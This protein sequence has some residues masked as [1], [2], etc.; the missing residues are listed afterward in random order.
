MSSSSLSKKLVLL[1]FIVV[2]L[3]AVPLTIFM[4]QRQQ[5]IRSR[6]APSTTLSFSPTTQSTTVGQ[7][8]SFD[9]MLDPGTNQV[10]FLKL[11]INYD[12]VKLAKGDDGLKANG[13][14]FPSTLE[15]PTFATNAASITLSIGA[16]PTKVIT[17]K[18]KAATISFT[19]L[20][21]T[22]SPTQITFGNA[23]QVLSIASSDTASE[24]V[25]VLS[26][27]TPG[28]VTIATSV[29]TGS[30][31]PT[32]TPTPTPTTTPSSSSTSSQGTSQAISQAPVPICSSLTTDTPGTGT[33][34]FTVIFTA[35]G[36]NPNGTISKITFNF[37]DNA[38]QDVT[39]A[40]GLG[41]SSISAQIS[42]TYTVS[43]TYTASAILTDNK[44]AINTTSCTQ[45]I[46][47]G[48]SGLA[49]ISPTI[50]PQTTAMAKPGPKETLIG[51]GGIATVLSI[52]G[53]VLLF[54]L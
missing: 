18:V 42:H 13:A 32:P 48:A 27:T 19:A 36:S 2:L 26:S 28:S 1:G 7:Q 52:I 35:T 24:N 54:A 6:A 37:G 16:D 17:T 31:A 38:I 39:Q 11:A 15:G 25:L 22:S 49:K 23:T 9:I 3:V 40:G 29:S 14:V 45:K 43:G 20:A 47:V 4:L 33:A 12:P 46:I 34:P 8:I 41:T 44:G 30:T 21:T 50:T 5:E 53:A 10:S 51:I